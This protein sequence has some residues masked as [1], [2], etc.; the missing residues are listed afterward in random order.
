MILAGL[1]RFWI[2]VSLLLLLFSQHGNSQVLG[3]EILE[4]KE[5]VEIDFEYSQGFIILDI[6]FSKALPLKFILDTGAEHVILF[7]Q[8][9]RRYTL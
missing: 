4:N 6:R 2:A 7:R 1:H 8:V 3:L 9:D 5:P